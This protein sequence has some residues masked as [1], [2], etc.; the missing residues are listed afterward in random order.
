MKISELGEFGLIARLDRAAQKARAPRSPSGRRLV[1]GIGDDA[2]AWKPPYRKIELATT[3]TMVEGVHFLT[4]TFD[5]PDLGWKSVASN[6]S[7]IAAMGGVPD[8]ALVSLCLP[9]TVE[10]ESAEAIF[11][12]MLDAAS[13]YSVAVIGGNLSKSGEIMLT[14]TVVGHLDGSA[15]LLRSEAKPGDKVAVTGSLGMASAALP[16]MK[17][18]IMVGPEMA[19]LFK[20]AHFRPE[21]RIPEGQAL[22]R[23]GV[24]AAI[25]ISDG[26]MGDLNH[27][28]EASH[29]GAIIQAASVPIDPEV[30]EVYIENAPAY[31]MLGGEDFELLFTA[32]SNIIEK[33]KA[34][35]KVPVSII[36]DIV[37]EHPGKTMVLDVDGHKITPA[38]PG[39]DHFKRR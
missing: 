31:A 34:E 38:M 39:W 8:Y 13:R 19:T 32:P 26:L 30:R 21:P 17:E 7:D 11:H 28:C 2:A 12:G 3:D 9:D 20:Q 25:D 18:A 4:G 36:G 16:I 15:M 5:W 35:L 37:S 10:A 24:R 22:L 6:L 14:L 1:M 23:A 33:V 29:V 27:I